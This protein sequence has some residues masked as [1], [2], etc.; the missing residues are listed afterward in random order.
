MMHY[1]EQNTI[2]YKNL[3][4]EAIDELIVNFRPSSNIDDI[5]TTEDIL[6]QQR[7]LNMEN[8][9]NNNNSNSANNKLPSLLKRNFELY[10]VRGPNSKNPITPI[11]SLK[12]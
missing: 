12:S 2:T 3:L 8:S 9:E 1:I 7:Q 6:N 5:L 10:I 11:R 4:S